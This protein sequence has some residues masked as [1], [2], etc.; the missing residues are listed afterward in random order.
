M[1]PPT[2][3]YVLD[4][5]IHKQTN[6]VNKTC[7]LLQTICVRHHYTQTNINNV[8]KTCALLQTTGGKDEPNIVCMRKSLTEITT[9]NSERK[10]T[11]LLRLCLHKRVQF[12]SQIKFCERRILAGSVLLIVLVFGIMLCYVCGKDCQ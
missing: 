9:R 12:C 6:N 2:T 7:A 11:Q 4:T 10:Y 3:Q 8:N 5:T 1:R